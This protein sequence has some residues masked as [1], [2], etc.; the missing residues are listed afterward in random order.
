MKTP[1]LTLFEREEGTPGTP[2]ESEEVN[3]E[4]ISEVE[5][6]D[7]LYDEID[8]VHVGNVE[9]AHNGLITTIYV[10]A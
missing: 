8:N 7:L 2:A 4:K 1:L 9:K 5:N 3:D 10:F 6:D